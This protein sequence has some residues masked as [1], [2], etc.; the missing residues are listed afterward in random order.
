MEPRLGEVVTHPS[1][2]TKLE[3]GVFDSC[4]SLTG[5]YMPGVTSI[6]MYAFDDCSSLMDVTIPSGVTVVSQLAETIA[7]ESASV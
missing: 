2:V 5:V 7:I 6:G 3:K 4:I 1:G